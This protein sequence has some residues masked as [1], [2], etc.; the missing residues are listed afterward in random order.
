MARAQL[1]TAGYLSVV[2]AALSTPAHSQ[3]IGSVEL[4][5]VWAY[6][7]PSGGERG[8]LYRNNPVH[9][10]ERVET[11]KSGALRLVFLD[12]TSLGLGSD[13]ALVLDQ[14]VYDPAGPDSM[15]LELGEGLFHFVTGD[16]EADAVV[17]NTPAMI[18]GVRGTDLAISVSADGFTE[19][20]VREGTGLATPSAGGPTVEVPAGS[21]ATAAP[22]D[23]AVLVREGLSATA[24]GTMP[25]AGAGFGGSTGNSGEGS[26]QGTGARSGGESGD[27]GTGGQ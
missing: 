4:V 12:D 16:M 19:L 27:S 3:E 8:D 17:I 14:L 24:A 21:T 11:V 2:L 15:V 22:G 6:S 20:G 10:G 18:V 7:T 23:S 26:A 1:F 5:R 13:S 25:G 9:A